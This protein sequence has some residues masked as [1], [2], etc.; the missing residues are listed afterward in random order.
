MYFGRFCWLNGI[1]WELKVVYWYVFFERKYGLVDFD[2]LIVWM[3]MELEGLIEDY[4]V[5]VFVV[6]EVG[7]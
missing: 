6:V 4:V 2:D 7:F 5:V 1:V 3:D